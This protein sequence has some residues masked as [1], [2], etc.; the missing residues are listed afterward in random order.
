MVMSWTREGEIVIGRGSD[1]DL[2]PDAED[3]SLSRRHAAI[4]VTASAIRIGD[5]GS[6][7]GTRVNGERLAERE[8][9]TLASGDVITFG[10]ETLVCVV[11][12]SNP[13]IVSR[14]ALPEDGWRQ[15]LSEEIER[16]VRYRRSLAV[17]SLTG[18][19]PEAVTGLGETVRLIDVV[20]AGESDGKVLLLMPEVERDEA[21]ATARTLI[22]A[23]RANHPVRGGLAMCPS[24]ACDA[25]TIL[26]AAR[27]AALAS[28]GGHTGRSI[29]CGDADR[30]RRP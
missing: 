9:R 27:N 14:P 24:D 20:G 1:T 4:R 18:V 23:L 28:G 5:L 12:L 7:N 21:C 16:A 2:R 10:S 3:A 30:A 22:D 29:Q 26:L 19:S 8:W 25:D 11:H 15:R 6:H 13:P 17:L